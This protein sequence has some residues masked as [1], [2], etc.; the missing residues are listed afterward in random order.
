ML[1][2]SSAQSFGFLDGH[3]TAFVSICCPKLCAIRGCHLGQGQ[4]TPSCPQIKNKPYDLT[5]VVVAVFSKAF[6]S[7]IQAKPNRFVRVIGHW[8][9]P[10]MAMPA[11]GPYHLYAKLFHECIG[12]VFFSKSCFV[13]LSFRKAKWRSLS[14]QQWL[15][16]GMLRQVPMP[17][18][19]LTSLEC[20][21]SQTMSSS[22]TVHISSGTYRNIDKL[23]STSYFLLRYG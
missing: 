6:I 4:K 23:F 21:P 8:N 13:E 17:S 22:S 7:L 2:P 15:L 14:N 19:R 20:W 18:S 5:K 16:P 10:L 9:A 12:F 3:L 11:F 1:L